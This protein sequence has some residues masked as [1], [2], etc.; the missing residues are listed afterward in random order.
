MSSSRA[1]AAARS[2]RTTSEQGARPPTFTQQS[3][4][5]P[6]T[7]SNG[8]TQAF[9]SDVQTKI[10]V[11][12]AINIV[13]RRI[14]RLEQMSSSQQQFQMPENSCVVDNAVFEEIIDRLDKLEST[15][16]ETLVSLRREFDI[17]L[18]TLTRETNE[19]IADID[20]AFAEIEKSIQLDND[21]PVDN[22]EI[23]S[24]DVAETIQLEISNA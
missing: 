21:P 17:K 18:E 15:Q 14:S 10:S 6:S 16:E 4:S 23:S 22:T 12:D 3:Q 19:K 20:L 5:Q 11:Q 7:P 9:V 1:I 24:A 8:R 13:A 2:R